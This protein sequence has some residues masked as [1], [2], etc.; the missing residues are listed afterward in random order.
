LRSL[1]ASYQQAP[2]APELRRE[3]RAIATRAA[4]SFG[5]TALPPLADFDL[6]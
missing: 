4:K 1:V 3:L 2:V 6:V 5:M